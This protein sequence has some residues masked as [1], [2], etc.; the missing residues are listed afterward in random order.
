M[1]PMHEPPPT[2]WFLVVVSGNDSGA[3]FELLGDKMVLGRA[4]SS[5]IVV[6]DEGVA[7][8]HLLFE[9]DGDGWRAIDQNTT[10]GGFKNGLRYSATPLAPN[11]RLHVGSR[12]ILRVVLGDEA[13]QVAEALTGAK[14]DFVTQ[15]LCKAALASELRAHFSFPQHPDAPLSFALVDVHSS[16]TLNDVHDSVASDDVLLHVARAIR[17]VLDPGDVVGRYERDRF[18]ISFRARDCAQAHDACERVRAAV[19]ASGMAT[20]SI[21]VATRM[22]AHVTV[23]HLV[24]A[25]DDQLARAKR[26]GKNRV[27]S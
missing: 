9:R 22:P 2:R 21:G 11:D 17:A 27:E 15:T 18:A 14:I 3:C 24:R 26:E 10:A 16:K 19:E 1:I 25:A 23:K 13:R 12:M 5:D 8:R 20:V 7:R 4:P 6:R